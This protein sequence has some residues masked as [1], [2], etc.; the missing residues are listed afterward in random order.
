MQQYAVVFFPKIDVEE[1]QGFREKYDLQY[2]VIPPH[3]TLVFPF[4]GISE[5]Q[6][7]KHIDRVIKHIKSFQIRLNGLEKSFD[8]YLFLRVKGGDEEIINLHDKLYSVILVPHLRTDIPFVPHVTLGYFRTAD[9]KFD[10]G[11]YEKAYVEALE[12]DIN[13]LDNFDNVTLIKGDGLSP[14]TII[15]TFK[16]E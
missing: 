5:E 11:L 4:S 1:I 2:N 15:Q 13:I 7:V 6:I 14:A 3:I 12:K 9:D 10:R 8:D 16:L